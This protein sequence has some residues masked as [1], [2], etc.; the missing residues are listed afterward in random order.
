MD[1]VESLDDSFFL[2]LR[3]KIPQGCGYLGAAVLV[4]SVHTL[5]GERV[6]VKI[7]LGISILNVFIFG[8]LVQCPLPIK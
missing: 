1:T 8:I 4:L 7:Q 6:S 3:T 2:K 5:M